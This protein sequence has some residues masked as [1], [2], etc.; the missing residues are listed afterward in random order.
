MDRVIVY[1]GA[2][3]A[4]ADILT[5]QRNA[6]LGLGFLAQ[7]TLGTSTIVDG[8]AASQ[9]TV[10]SLSINIGPGSI[11][12]LSTIDATPYGSLAADTTDPLVKMGINI[13][14]TVLSLSGYVPG[15]SGQQVYVLVEASLAETDTGS[16]VLSY[17]NASNPASPYS[18]PSNSGTAQN[19]ARVQRVS[20]QLKA[21]T[22]SAS[23][24][25]PATDSGWTALYYVLLSY[26]QTQITTAQ[27]VALPGAPFVPNKLPTL[28]PGFA[29]IQFITSTTTWTVPAYV[30][31]IRVR[32][33]GAGG[34]GGGAGGTASSATGGSGGGHTDGIFTVVP[35]TAYT[36]TVGTGG[37]AGA[38]TGGNGGTGGTTSFG[39]L[40]SATGGSGGTGSA[41]GAASGSPTAGTGSG[42]LLNLPGSTSANAYVSG[43]VY[44]GS[45]GAGSPFG[46]GNGWMTVSGGNQVYPGGGGDGGGANGSAH[47]GATGAAG[48]VIV[49]W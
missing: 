6:M 44:W 43:A 26:A 45:A 46:G 32:A 34:G 13:A 49:E 11:T 16:T 21:G 23:P 20:L 24:V 17:Y 38:S 14:P 41:S 4:S 42:G 18:G 1:P 33:W 2:L 7:A 9:T 19:T 48:L 37:T 31:R 30:T 40:C 35:G 10:A 29:H 3:P 47:A 12:S 36:V 28:T 25:M 22:P 8:L 5:L 27:I 15:T 39:A